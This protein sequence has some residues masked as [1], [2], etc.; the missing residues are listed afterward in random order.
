M[1]LGTGH[2]E[3]IDVWSIGVLMY[4]MHAGKAPFSAHKGIKDIRQ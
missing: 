3:K 1:I 4:E 2:D